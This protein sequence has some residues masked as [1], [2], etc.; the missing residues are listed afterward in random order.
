MKADDVQLLDTEAFLRVMAEVYD[1]TKKIT[2]EFS[3]TEFAK[4]CLDL[5]EVVTEQDKDSALQNL[6]T[7]SG[8]A[9]KQVIR[10]REITA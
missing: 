9:I 2:D 4:L 6:D 7:M 3:G 10:N 8:F 1:A 5:Y